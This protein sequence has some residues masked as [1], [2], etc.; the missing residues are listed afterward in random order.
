MWLGAFIAGSFSGVRGTRSRSHSGGRPGMRLARG[1][2]VADHTAR[3]DDANRC[4]SRCGWLHRSGVRATFPFGRA[5]SS[6]NRLHVT[7]GR[8]QMGANI[9]TVMVVITL[10]AGLW[11]G[12]SRQRHKAMLERVLDRRRGSGGC[13]APGGGPAL[14]AR[15]VAGSRSRGRGGCCASALAAGSLA[16][17]AE[18]GWARRAGRRAGARRAGAPDR[19]RA[20]AAEAV[21]AASCR[22]RDLPLDRH[23]PSRDVHR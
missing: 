20:D 21:G 17:L 18:G 7:R 11:W 5:S 12:F 4:R 6:L 19:G 9:D 1:C 15:S 22:Q 8:I 16:P 23:R 13:D 10:A 14:A 3:R 2:G